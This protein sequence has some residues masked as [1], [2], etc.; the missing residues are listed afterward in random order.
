VPLAA[1]ATADSGPPPPPEFSL[2]VKEGKL[3]ET[4]HE[5]DQHCLE[6]GRRALLKG[7]QPGSPDSLARYACQ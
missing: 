4:T 1:C 5:A 6:F 2:P 7:V 3:A